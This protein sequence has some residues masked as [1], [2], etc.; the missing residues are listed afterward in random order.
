MKG[1]MKRCAVCTIRGPCYKVESISRNKSTFC[2]ALLE[3]SASSGVVET[4]SHSSDNSS[5][6]V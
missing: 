4:K 6:L 1:A 3:C 5:L 2:S